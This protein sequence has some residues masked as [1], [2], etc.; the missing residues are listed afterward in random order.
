VERTRRRKT[1]SA[2]M[3]KKINAVYYTKFSIFQ[4]NPHGKGNKITI[5]SP[6]F[7]N[8]DRKIAEEF[9]ILLQNGFT[10]ILHQN[11]EY[12]IDDVLNG[13]FDNQQKF[14][15]ENTFIII[16]RIILTEID[17]DAKSRIA[18]SVQIACH[19]S[20]GK[21]YIRINGNEP[22]LFSNILEADGMVF[23]EIVPDLFSFNSPYGACPDCGGFGD[24]L[25]IDENKVIPNTSLSV[26]D[27][28]VSCWEGEKM[29]EWRKDFIHKAPAYNFRIFEPYKNLSEDEKNLLWEGN[30]DVQGIMDFCR[31]LESNTYKIH[32]RILLSRL[33]GRTKCRSCKGSR[34]RKEA[35]YVKINQRSINELLLMPVDEL[36]ELLK[37]MA[38]THKNNKV[39]IRLFKE[40]N[41]RVEMMV[42][43][44]LGYLTLN[45]SS[46]SLSGGESQRIQLIYALGSK[47]T[48]TLYIL[49]E[50][51]IGLHS[52]DTQQLIAV[53]NELKQLGNTVIVVEH[54]EDIIRS[55]N[56][57][58]DLGPGAGYL[59]GN[60]IFQGDYKNAELNPTGFTADYLNGKLNISLRK[61]RNEFSDFIFIENASKHN[62][63]NIDVAIPLNAMTVVCGVSGSGKTTLVSDIIYESLKPLSDAMPPDFIG[64]SSISIQSTIN[65]D[66]NS[67]SAKANNLRKI[68]RIEFVGQDSIDRSKRSNAVTYLKVFD[69]I[70]E[71]M[72]SVPL[73]KM[74]GYTPAYFSFNVDGGRCDE[75]KGDGTITVE[76]QFLADMNLICDECKGKRYKSDILE[77]TYK[78]KNIDDILN[79]TVAE[80]V[81]FFKEHKAIVNGLDPLVKTGLDYLKLGQPTSSL[82]GGEAQRLKLAGFLSKG[83]KNTGHT[84][85]I[86][87]EP[88]TGLHWHDIQKLTWW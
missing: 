19:E 76:M 35:F 70:R 40:I 11:I 50:P 37:D 63:Q 83:F 57:I 68:E 8:A 66:N 6:L 13:E 14:D 78:G 12:L 21:C 7:K 79:L 24:T 56:E 85:F 81:D 36:W 82:S 32:Y 71:L 69:A 31:M 51:S 39:A 4:E 26:Y 52:K 28:A 77:V 3:K 22:I 59:G 20:G 74:N 53:L 17:E 54:D 25:G 86:F 58:I 27:K 33:K 67:K 15:F 45:R 30:G 88:T 65:N 61:K 10:K 75:C 55:A 80:A 2:F 29:G 38:N 48:G 49:D 16:D 64:C 46:R 73:S 62:L 5:L 23:D 84:L 72:S 9:A 47:L 34:L 42:N 44:G 60:I 1:R 43:T 18:D 87:D 41:S